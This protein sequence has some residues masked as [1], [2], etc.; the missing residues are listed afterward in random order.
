MINEK[1]NASNTEVKED[2]APVKEQDD[3]PNSKVRDEDG[4]LLTVYHGTRADFDTYDTSKAGQNYEG[5]WSNNGKGIY[6]TDNKEEAMEYAKSSIDEGDPKVKEA[7]LD[8]TN[9]FDSSK[10]Y[11]N[12]LSEMAKEYGIEPYYL[13]RGDRL[14]NWFNTNKKDIVEALSKYGYDG[15]VDHGHYTVFDNKQIKSV[16]KAQP[17]DQKSTYFKYEANETDSI[18]KKALY[19]SASKVMNDS[20][21]SHKFADVVAKISEDIL[22]ILYLISDGVTKLVSLIS[23][24]SYVYFNTK[25]RNNKDEWQ[26]G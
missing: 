16:E 8:I 9:P 21:M 6:F 22:F 12:E 26:R 23:Y 3:L 7:Q 10:D 24:L 25:R 13:E 19:E 18:Y 14:F 2:I 1:G 4:K 17:K 11:T 15:I 20:K 5:N